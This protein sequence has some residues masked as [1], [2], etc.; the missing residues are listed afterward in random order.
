[1]VLKGVHDAL[2]GL[3]AGLRLIKP[4]QQYGKEGHVIAQGKLPADAV[5]LL[6]IP[7]DA[8]IVGM[9][10]VKFLELH[11][12]LVYNNIPEHRKPPRTSRHPGTSLQLFLMNSFP[13]FLQLMAILPF[14]FGTRIF[15]LQFGHL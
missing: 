5:L 2:A 10:Y 7:A 15:C 14:P 8:A 11:F 9:V 12:C 3:P 13:H 1:M 4:C 6:Q